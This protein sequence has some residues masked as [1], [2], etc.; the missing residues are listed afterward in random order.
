MGG[1]CLDL[2]R[3]SVGDSDSNSKQA[4]ESDGDTSFKSVLRTATL[5]SRSYSKSI[6]FQV[7]SLRSSL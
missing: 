2:D 1:H 4:S 3:G 7:T 5:P 6:F